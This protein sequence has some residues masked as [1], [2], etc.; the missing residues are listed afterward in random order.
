MS[1]LM[2]PSKGQTI[3]I[4]LGQSASKRLVCGL[5]WDPMET[6]QSQLLDGGAPVSPGR[7]GATDVYDLDLICLC[8][9]KNGAY[10]GGVTGEE[11]NHNADHGNI[12]HTGDVVDGEDNHDDEQIMFELFNMS[13]EIHSI[14]IIAE[15]QS[16]HNFGDIRLPKIRIAD[17][18]S[19]NNFVNIPLGDQGFES[20]SAFVLG[21]LHRDGPE[22]AL[23]YIGDYC[24]V[25]QV[26]DWSTSLISYL[27]LSAPAQSASV[28][29]PQNLNAGEIAKLKYSA[30]AR[31]R[32]LCGLRWDPID[33]DVKTGI[34]SGPE[35][36]STYDL[37]LAC[38]LFDEH[39]D[40][41]DGVSAQPE[42]NIDDTG[43][44]YHSGDDVD[45]EGDRD[46]ETISVE[47]K[48]LPEHIHHIIFVAEI[49]SSHS[50]SDI[51]NPAI[52]IADAKTDKSQL[53]IPLNDQTQQDKNG[54]I[55]ARM[56]RHADGWMVHFIDEF[57]HSENI[58]DL[59]SHLKRYLN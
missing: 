49:Q 47:L 18:I 16:A 22:W 32:V 39:G 48:E 44:V 23:E 34:L 38:V 2:P 51:I 27:G 56:F 10:L 12:Y 17:P 33:H 43:F 36:I 37:D 24:H 59:I 40:A 11:G 41:I 28:Q 13:S 46:D 55:F 30:E 42:E 5:R 9:D 21:R 15:I 52:R 19:D 25:G 57:F 7:G 54:Y 26:R 8:Y 14:F 35:N 1:D 20:H 45:G 53:F 4:D 31:H 6:T 29:G 3:P 50:F 58:P